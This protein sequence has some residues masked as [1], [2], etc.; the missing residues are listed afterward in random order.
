MIR[1]NKNKILV[2]FFSLL[3]LYTQKQEKLLQ[4]ENYF[5]TILAD[6]KS[7]ITIK[8]EREVHEF[9]CK[10]KLSLLR[11]LSNMKK[12][13]DSYIA[14]KEIDLDEELKIEFAKIKNKEV[15]FSDYIDE[16]SSFLDSPLFNELAYLFDRSIEIESD[17]K[18]LDQDFDI[19]V[20]SSLVDYI[21]N[22]F[23]DFYLVN[24]SY[25]EFSNQLT[26]DI[27]KFMKKLSERDISEL[28]ELERIELT[29]IAFERYYK[30]IMPYFRTFYQV[31]KFINEDSSWN[32]ST[33]INYLEIL[34][35]NV[36]EAE[37]LVLFYYA[38]YTFE[39]E[40]LFDE[41][42]RT[43]FFGEPQE[44][45]ENVEPTFFSK[46]DLLW[47]AD[48]LA[49]MSEKEQLLAEKDEIRAEKSMTDILF[50]LFFR[51]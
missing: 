2:L 35:A 30:S 18:E 43:T 33:K 14:Q 6:I 13:I 50:S 24:D 36:T 32:E 5:S 22:S 39:G 8:L 42:K 17:C 12:E 47:E 26:N 37:M 28:T 15:K 45:L 49:I 41:L 46:S 20:A 25:L 44:L 27:D 38:A 48:D 16:N 34:R 4:E 7:E 3:Q 19:F 9:I 11:I 31:L 40:E 29:Q 10:N 23:N 21:T 51:K 1:E